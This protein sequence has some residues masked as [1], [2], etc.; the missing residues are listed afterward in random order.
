MPFEA[1]ESLDIPSVGISNFTWYTAYQ[2]L[3]DESELITF[4]EAYQKM[5]YFYSLAGSQEQWDMGKS[6]FGFFSREVDLNEVKRIRD[7]VNPDNSRNIIFIGLGM[8]IDVGTLEE[9]T[10]WDSLNCVFLVSSNVEVDR[11]NVFQIPNDYL[12]SQ[13]Y[14]AASDLVI[15]KAGWGMVG[16]A[17]SSLVPLLILNR[18]SMGEDQNTINY[19]K[20]HQLCETIEWESFTSY[21]LDTLLIDNLKEGMDRYH[22]NYSN[23]A[24]KIA[25]DSL[26]IIGLS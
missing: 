26:D 8:K 10:I 17:V 6:E 2:G 9:L 21:Q 25:K 15:S 13:N 18:P 16:E 19:L 5:S 24:E 20:Q 7:L 11:P 23:Q 1:A 4:K 3:I 14:I 12:E 22:S